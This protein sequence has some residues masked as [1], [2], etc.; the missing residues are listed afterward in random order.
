LF[1][2]RALGFSTTAETDRYHVSTAQSIG[3]KYTISGATANV[4]AHIGANTLGDA[5]IVKTIGALCIGAATCAGAALGILPAYM[6]IRSATQS[7]TII[8]ASTY[9]TL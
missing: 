3:I 4:E 6:N 2:G 1:E 9:T 5:A 7:L 8:F